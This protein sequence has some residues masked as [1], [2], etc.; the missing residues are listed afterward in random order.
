MTYPFGR[1]SLQFEETAKVSSTIRYLGGHQLHILQHPPTQRGED[2]P[3]GSNIYVVVGYRDKV[4]AASQ[5]P[6]CSFYL[7]LGL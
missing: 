1:F 5:C 3:I 6:E 4:E 2:L 7:A